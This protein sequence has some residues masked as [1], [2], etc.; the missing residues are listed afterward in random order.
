VNAVIIQVKV[1]GLSVGKTVLIGLLFAVLPGSPLAVNAHPRIYFT[2]DDLPGMVLKVSGRFKV[3]YLALRDKAAQVV[4]EPLDYKRRWEYTSLLSFVALM[5]KALGRDNDDYLRKAYEYAEYLGKQPVALTSREWVPRYQIGQNT[6]PLG[7]AYDW[8]YEDLSE[9]ERSRLVGYIKKWL[10]AGLPLLPD[11][12]GF[13]NM[14]TLVGHGLVTAIL[15]VYGDKELGGSGETYLNAAHDLLYKVQLPAVNTA[16]KNGGGWHEGW[17]YGWEGAI[18]PLP[19]EMQ[20]WY[21]ATGEN[22]FASCPALED[23]PLH[24]VYI[25]RPY[26]GLIAHLDRNFNFGRTDDSRLDNHRVF[27]ALL[28]ARYKDGYA[29]YL[30]GLEP[31]G[32]SYSPDFIYDIIWYDP[33]VEPRR[34]KDGEIPNAVHFEGQG[35]VIIRSGFESEDDTFFLFR[36]RD[37]YGG[38]TSFGENHFALHK[39]AGLALRS[40]QY[41]GWSSPN[42]QNYYMKTISYNSI[43]I[44]DP[45]EI[46]YWGE[47]RDGGQVYRDQVRDI[48]D[49]SFETRDDYDYARGDATRAYTSKKLRLFVRKIIHLKPDDLFLVLDR[50]ETTDAGFT[51]KWIMH[52]TNR[53]RISE[54]GELLEVERR[55]GDVLNIADYRGDLATVSTGK[56]RLFV[57]T[58]LPEKHKVRVVGGPG[59]EFWVD[60]PGRNYPL[61]YPSTAAEPGN[62]RIEV[63]PEVESRYDLFLHLLYPTVDP[64]DAPPAGLLHKGEKTVGLQVR[65]WF[66]LF[67][68]GEAAQDS[69]DYFLASDGPVKHLLTDLRRGRAT[70]YCNGV[71]TARVKV[72]AEG[73]VC[74][75]SDSGG[76]F[77]IKVQP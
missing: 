55:T 1:S 18:G 12:T 3:Q 65:D 16:G 38:N 32:N 73:N 37:F 56:S 75:R 11:H 77:S 39:G 30:A 10:D 62:W 60:D 24:F 50:V 6:V 8:L 54:P 7:Q 61:K 59:Y 21:S 19:M 43:L 25:R 47:T 51:K 29:Q 42:N 31:V 35:L 15:A 33:S 13:H 14:T 68:R 4:D 36:A 44:Y 69:V 2:R 22:V 72:S 67:S 20:A 34:P 66:V 64:D 46:P 27:F 71:E 23:L 26:N 74:F 52:A 9:S 28:A 45:T 57:R 49:L 63:I 5:E 70:I 76:H 41:D 48:C 40:G 53:P 17:A 58:F